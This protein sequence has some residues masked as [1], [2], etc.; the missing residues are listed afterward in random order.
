MTT[1]REPYPGEIKYVYCPVC[2][3]RVKLTCRQ[4]G[5]HWIWEGTCPSCGKRITE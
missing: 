4:L 3:E 1:V 5:S 2:G